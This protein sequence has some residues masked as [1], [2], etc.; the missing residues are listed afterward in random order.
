MKQSDWSIKAMYNYS[1]D[2]ET[3]FANDPRG[4]HK[5]CGIK[6]HSK[7]LIPRLRKIYE[8]REKKVT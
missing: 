1:N 5:R 4:Q 8:I 3:L 6:I 7:N 2:N